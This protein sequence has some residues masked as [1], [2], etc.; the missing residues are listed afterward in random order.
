[1][2]HY[3]YSLELRNIVRYS[4]FIMYGI[5]ELFIVISTL[6]QVLII[7]NIDTESIFF[8]CVSPLASVASHPKKNIV[9]GIT[10]GGNT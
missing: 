3:T 7:L 9:E 4:K 5:Q 10:S 6:F 1:M 2:I 8:R